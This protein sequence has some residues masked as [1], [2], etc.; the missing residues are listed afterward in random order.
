MASV[1]EQ[2]RTADSIFYAGAATEIQSQEKATDAVFA[3]LEETAKAYEQATDAVFAE[4]ERHYEQTTD[5]IFA[6]GEDL[7]LPI[8]ELETVKIP[9]YHFSSE[10]RDAMLGYFNRHNQ[11]VDK[12]MDKYAFFDNQS[13]NV[14]RDPELLEIR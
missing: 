7:T 10:A 6:S 3:E 4:P 2:P 9:R 8:L 11:A 1:L 14:I 13:D 5:V 12:I